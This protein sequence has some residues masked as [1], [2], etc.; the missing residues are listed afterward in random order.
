MNN[1][2]SAQALA[3]TLSQQKKQNESLQMFPEKRCN[4]PRVDCLPR[5]LGSRV[6][7]ARQP[8]YIQ[9]DSVRPYLGDYLA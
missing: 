6:M 3:P 5:Q 2:G 1:R 4:L 7:A 9:I 8:H